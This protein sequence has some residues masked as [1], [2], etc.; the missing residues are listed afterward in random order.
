M[1]QGSEIETVIGFTERWLSIYLVYV[2]KG[3]KYD[4]WSATIHTRYV[5][6]VAR[7]NVFIWEKL[8]KSILTALKWKINH[9]ALQNKYLTT[10]FVPELLW[11]HFWWWWVEVAE[12][13]VVIEL[14]AWSYLY[15]SPPWALIC[16]HSIHQIPVKLICNF[17]NFILMASCSEPCTLLTNTC[18]F[19]FCLKVREHVP[20]PH[21][22][23][24]KLAVYI[25]L[26][27]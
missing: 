11:F 24:G 13:Y 10:S 9:A 8:K 20:C 19:W 27:K 26:W 25:E 16:T 3:R 5:I 15:Q 18:A 1:W 23:T 6:S 4:K 7:F 17:P 12:G 14:E 22:L 2:D 21:K